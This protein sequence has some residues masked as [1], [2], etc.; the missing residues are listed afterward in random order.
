MDYSQ[1]CQGWIYCITN[2]VN[3][4]RYIGQTDNFKRRKHEHFGLGGKWCP[5]LHNAMVKYG[6]DN[7]EMHAI[8]TFTA[9]NRKVCLDIL[10]QLEIFYIRKFHSL[11]HENGYNVT[12]GGKGMLGY[13]PNEN[14]RRKLS[15][16]KKTREALEIIL[17]NKPD[18]RRAV[19]MYDLE[20]RFLRGHKSI[21]DAVRYCGKDEHSG[22]TG[23][24]NALGNSNYHF[25][26]YLWRYEESKYF[27]LFIDPYKDIRSKPVFHYTITGQLIEKYSSAREAA[28]ATGISI[29]TINN[30]LDGEHKGRKRRNNYWSHIPPN[31]RPDC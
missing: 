19:L 24:N 13:K 18:N 9:I 22:L 8:V 16:K 1:V 26:G 15:E 4:K 2:K 23:I 27:P 14:I 29:K 20:G 6:I 17:K 7:F 11:S 30:S 21:I 3:G 31:V 12:E 10:N 28:K 25:C 5:V